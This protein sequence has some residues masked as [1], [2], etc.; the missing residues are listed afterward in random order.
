M[1]PGMVL[2]GG[3][4]I[5]FWLDRFA[6]DTQGLLVSQDGDVLGTLPAL[7]KA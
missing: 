1:E 5:A 6:I 3:Q 7:Q 4:A 2:V